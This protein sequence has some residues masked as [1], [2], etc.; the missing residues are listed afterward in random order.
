MCGI[1]GLFDIQGKQRIS[2]SALGPMVGALHHR[3]P[4]QKGAYLDKI[5]GLG[6]ARLSIIDLSSGVQPIHNEDRT[7]WIVLNGEIYNYR[8]LR[9]SLETRGH[10][11]YTNTD[12][13]VILH[14]YEE[15]GP[16]CVHDFNGQFAFAIWDAGKRSLFL[17]RDHFGICPLFYAEHNGLFLFASEIKALFASR[18]LPRP[19]IDPRALDQI[20][21]FWTTL[22]GLTAFKNIHELKPGHTL[23]VDAQG[24]HLTR[25]WD[26]PYIPPDSCSQDPPGQISEHVLALLMDATRL[27]L[28]ADVPVGSYL[29]G[30]LDS[31]GITALIARHFNK[32]VRTFGVRFREKDFDEGNYQNEMAAHLRVRH[33]E[34]VA[35]NASIADAFPQVIWHCETPILRTA[36]VPMFLLSRFVRQQGIKVVCTGEGADEVFGGYDIFREALVRRF[37][38]RQPDSKYRPML[39]EHLYPQIFKSAREKSSFRQFVLHGPTDIRDPFFSHIVRWNNTARIKQ[40]FSKDLRASIGT[41]SAVDELAAGLPE[42]FANRD[43]LSKAQYLEDN[44]F[45]SNY[46]LSSQGDRMAMAHSVEIR[47]PYLDFRITD[48][49]SRVPALWKILGIDEKHILKKVFTGILPSSIIRRTKQPYRAPIQRAFGA[50]LVSDRYRELLSEKKTRE[51]GLFDAPKVSGLLSKLASGSSTSEIEGMAIAGIASTHLLVE[52]FIDDFRIPE[53]PLPKWDV[54]FDEGAGRKID[55]HEKRRS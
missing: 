42:D 26:L 43:L 47:P 40:F 29:S 32:D 46:L 9:S 4:D 13:E 41:Y 20:F 1:A 2:D 55:H 17:A 37:V 15:N 52:H 22:P 23:T 39:L 36:P 25:Y 44:L 38:S 49:M 34:F 50:D 35:E 11:F 27:R 21:T 28:R 48:F 7:V 12:T 8:E 6:H 53:T 18:L 16:D 33:H 30:G 3:G 54:W 14:H 45:L 24:R 19:A 5:V 31:S 10:R 51:V